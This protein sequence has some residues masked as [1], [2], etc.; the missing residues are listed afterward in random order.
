M[1]RKLISFALAFMLLFSS[2][3][4]EISLEIPDHNAGTAPEANAEIPSTSELVILSTT[5]MHG[6]CWEQNILTGDPA[7]Q[8]MLRVSTAVQEIRKQYGKENVI[9]IDN[10][11]LFQ[12]TPVSEMHLIHTEHAEEEKEAMSLCLEEI[13]YDV[14]VPGN[15]E[16][17][18]SW[19]LMSGI[20]EDLRENDTAML[21][22]N[23]YYDGSDIDHAAGENAFDPYMI[24]ELTVNG[25]LHKIGILGLENCD[26]TRWDG[27]AN[28]HGMCFTHPDNP[29]FDLGEEAG[30]YLAEMHA[31]GCEMIILSYHGGL[32]N[33]NRPLVFGVNSDN[34]GQRILESTDCLDLLILGH[35]HTSSY[36]NTFSTDKAGRPV[37][38]VNGGGNDLTKTVFELSED[39]EGN[40]RCEFVSSEN[41]SLSEYEPDR[42]LEEKIRPYAELA[43]SMM[44]MPIGE[45]S[46]A[47]DGSEERYLSQNRTVDLIFAAMIGVGTKRMTAKYEGPMEVAPGLD[48]LEVDC[49][50]SSVSGIGYIVHSGEVSTR[51]IYRMY[52]YSDN[53]MVLPM[54][55]REIKAV[56][57]ENA[58]ER[59]SVRVLNGQVYFLTK[60]DLNTNI[61]FG[62]V[63]FHYDMSKPAGERVVIDGFSNGRPFDPDKVYLIAVNSYILG[64]SKCG[65][66]DFSEND[67]LWS[68][69]S[70]DA[71]AV[72]QDLIQ[73][74]VITHCEDSG[75]LTPDA[76]QW[77]WYVTY[78]ADPAALPP[79]NG[80]TAAHL[81]EAPQNG[82]QYIIY[83]EAQGCT[84]TA[85]PDSGGFTALELPSH[86]N[87]LTGALPEEAQVFTAEMHGED[88]LF[89]V[90]SEGRYLSCGESG[91]LFLTDEAAE[92]DLSLWHILP[93]NGGYYLQ[94]ADSSVNQA[95]QY[96]GGRFTTYTL[97]YNNTFLINFYDVNDR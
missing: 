13:G 90:D 33:T 42:V 41:L 51:D 28:Y 15:H 96:Y 50:C 18:Y 94:S 48:H 5:D 75:S 67:T 6:K 57:E 37:P 76:I 64:N 44:N 26:I 79:Y 68:Q 77:Q 36:S 47:W 12:G 9:L 24:R 34:Q 81:A 83:Q 95:L 22:A 62:G 11:D 17:N 1:T 32:G 23:V 45:L 43:E 80:P 65:L 72:I 63:N 52:K 87:D 40:L 16:F 27:P 78:S 54:Y 74:Y 21:A 49:A 89:L 4:I 70:D 19:E 91:G 73:E 29:G 69:V 25:H 8:N 3:C 14:M 53:I 39:P 60:N 55:G 2:A 7:K 86:G 97:S 58:S 93:A 30:K 35:D 88:T 84:L 31:E 10:G 85:Q 56:M 92:N 82:H 66:R 61:V 46:G 59:L 71:G 38:I 20:Y